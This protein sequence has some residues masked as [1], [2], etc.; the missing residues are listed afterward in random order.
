MPACTPG[1]TSSPPG[2]ARPTSPASD[3]TA[4][5]AQAAQ[6]EHHQPAPAARDPADLLPPRRTERRA[7]R[8]AARGR[9]RHQLP[10]RAPARRLVRVRRPHR[11]PGLLGPGRRGPGRR[12]P[13][14]PARPPR[15]TVLRRRRTHPLDRSHSRRRHPAGGSHRGGRHPVRDRRLSAY[16]AGLG[17]A[18]H[19][20][21]DR[22]GPGPL[23]HHHHR[24]HPASH[25]PAHPRNHGSPPG[26]RPR[27]RHRRT[28]RHPG[29]RAQDD[30]RE[31]PFRPRRLDPDRHHR[32]LL[33]LAQDLGSRLRTG[34]EIAQALTLTA[35]YADRT[36]TTRT[37]TEPT[38]HTPALAATARQLLTGLGL[39][40][41]RIRTSALRAER[42]RPAEDTVR[43]LTLDDPDD[44]L[45]RLETAL[46]KATARCG[47]GITGAA[48]TFPRAG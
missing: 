30:E 39:Q 26:P 18:R 13:A 31:P 44:K 21:P 17:T 8:A 33:G 11:R 29:R 1:A 10:G 3:T 45:H 14:A 6:D 27:T 47:P 15:R 12:A 7:V 41:A 4:Q 16:E 20:P 25:P 23:R 42:L 28:P 19:W 46:E 2:P 32:T 24:R 9:R 34:G 37:L 22:P 43:Q 40:R 38:A 48:A 36:Q 5:A 35:T